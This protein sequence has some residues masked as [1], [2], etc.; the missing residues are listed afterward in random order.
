MKKAKNRLITILLLFFLSYSNFIFLNNIKNNASNS[1][2]QEIKKNPAYS[3]LEDEYNL[4]WNTTWGGIDNDESYMLMLDSLNN[5]YLSGWTY[6]LGAGDL[7]ALLIKMDQNGTEK[8]NVT[9]G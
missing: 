6:S 3:S 1:S 4:E 2:I 9:W 8:W 5:F 7:D